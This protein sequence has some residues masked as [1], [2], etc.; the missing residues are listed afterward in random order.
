M[1]D[2]SSRRPRL[3][4]AMIVCNAQDSIQ[5]T[6]DCATSMADEVVVVDTGS[7]DRT[8]QIVR[9]SQAR[10]IETPWGDDFSAARNLCL[11]HVQ[12]DWVLWL[13]AGEHLRGDDPQLLAEFAR[14][15]ADGSRAYLLLVKIP[16]GPESIQASRRPGS[17]WSPTGRASAIRGE[18]AKASW[19]RWT[20]WGFRWRG[21]PGHSTGWS[22]RTPLHT[23][24]RRHNGTCGLPNWKWPRSGRWHV[25]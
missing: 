3:S 19:H 22:P 25:C 24:R 15:R 8:L 4:V 20:A 2:T 7:T 14:G 12:G 16:P 21:Y 11:S 17:A 13:D 18:F 10:L 9:H 5:T 1:P 23:S 6:L